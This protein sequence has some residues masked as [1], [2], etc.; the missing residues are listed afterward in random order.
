MKNPEE[1]SHEVK[2]IIS[3]SLSIPFEQVSELSA[4][5]DLSADSIQLFELL[6]AFEKFYHVETSYEDIVHLNTVHDV[7]QYVT[8]VKYAV[9]S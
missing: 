3:D 5:A 2:T 7:V 1:I 8:K 6:L 9:A 4:I